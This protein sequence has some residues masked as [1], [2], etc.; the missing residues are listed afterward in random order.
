MARCPDCNRFRSG[1]PEVEVQDYK[2]ECSVGTETAQF[3]FR[4]VIKCE[5]CGTELK[6]ATLEAEVEM[7]DECPHCHGEFRPV[8][9]DGKF[10]MSE[11]CS[12]TCPQQSI[13]CEHYIV[14]EGKEPYCRSAKEEEQ[15]NHDRDKWEM[16]NEPDVTVEEETRK[17]KKWYIVDG[18]AT[19]ICTNCLQQVEKH[20]CVEECGTN[21]EDLN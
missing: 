14:E 7:D 1:E 9:V 11:E 20:V 15:D 16:D 19:V 21:F 8:D 2:V 18:T 13:A 3:E 10:K 5:E 17:G 4:I 12:H 6:E